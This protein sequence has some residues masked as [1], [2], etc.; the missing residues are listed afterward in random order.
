[1]QAVVFPRFPR[2]LFS[3]RISAGEGPLKNSV[4][5][6]KIVI[7]LSFEKPSNPPSSPFS[8]GEKAESFGEG[9]QKS[10]PPFVKGGREGFPRM[11]FQKAKLI[12]K[13]YF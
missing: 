4:Q 10:S 2:R 12:P 13:I 9:I 8:K 11:P 7:L 3:K 6:A 1:L 5:V